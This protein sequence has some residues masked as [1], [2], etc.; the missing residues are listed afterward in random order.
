MGKVPTVDDHLRVSDLL[1]KVLEYCMLSGI[2][3]V[4]TVLII[5]LYCIIYLKLF[6]CLIKMP[7]FSVSVD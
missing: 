3:E 4:F 2:S 5:I 7:A 1:R 6:V